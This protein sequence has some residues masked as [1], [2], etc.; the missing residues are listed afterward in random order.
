MMRLSRVAFLGLFSLVAGV[1]VACGGVDVAPT[2]ASGT[3]GTTTTSGAGGAGGAGT[4]ASTTTGDTTAGTG[5][6]AGSGPDIGQPSDVYPA[7]H[8]PPPTVVSLGGPVLAKPTFVPVFFSNDDAETIAKLKDFESNIGATQY[9][10]ATTQEYGVGPGVTAPPI[11]LP[12]AAPNAIDD[13]E[14]QAWLAGKLNSDDPAFGPVPVGAIYTLHYPMS[15]VI[16]DG[17]GG[18]GGGSKSCVAFG[19]YHNSIT[20]DAAHGSKNVAYAVIPHC[21]SFGDLTGIDAVT[22]P[23]SHELIEAATD[24]YPMVSPAFAQMDN[25][26]IYW[27]RLIGGG[28]TADMCAQFREAFTTFP[29]IPDYVVQRSWSNKAAKAGHDPCVPTHE[30]WVYFNAAPV[31]KDT[32]KAT[33]FG[34]QF[35]V[36]GIHIPEGE[37]KVVDIQLFSDADTGGPWSVEVRDLAEIIGGQPHLD[38]SLDADSGQNG[39]TLH[40]SIT[41]NSVGKSKTESFIVI[42]KLGERTNVWLG[43][44]GN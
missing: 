36:K 18:P 41:V 38:I 4:T 23:V 28:E 24:P 30:G 13:N 11:D 12:E 34:Q 9:W 16:S 15:T 10:A 1:G 32:I 3:T 7:P 31:M 29:E 21:P 19:G 22:G 20:L 14:I 6:T 27:M 17:S 26:H 35:S 5:G 43:I 25:N 33:V 37:T 39:Q 2:G 8:G 40:A 44:I 42:S